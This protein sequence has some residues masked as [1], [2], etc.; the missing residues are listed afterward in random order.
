MVAKSGDRLLDAA[1][2][3]AYVERL[4]PLAALVTPNLHEAEALLGRPVRDVARD[5]GRRAR[6][7]RRSARARCS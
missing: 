5:A 3:R 7:A 6:A 1:A 4:F 2:E